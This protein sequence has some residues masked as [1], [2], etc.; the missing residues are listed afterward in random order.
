MPKLRQGREI[1]V[2]S[3]VSRSFP[4]IP[5]LCAGGVGS[6]LAAKPMAAVTQ[7]E[8]GMKRSWCFPPSFHTE[9]QSVAHPVASHGFCP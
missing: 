5:V 6:K 7:Q 8:I 4:F 1:K 3:A 2:G 9:S